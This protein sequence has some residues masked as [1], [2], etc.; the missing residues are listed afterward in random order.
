MDLISDYNIRIGD[1][2]MFMQCTLV[3]AQNHLISSNATYVIQKLACKVK[4][5]SQI[6]GV[7]SIKLV[8]SVVNNMEK[9]QYKKKEHNQYSSVFKALR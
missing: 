4:N 9:N 5:I 6:N 8:G 1:S 3:K 7:G 2:K